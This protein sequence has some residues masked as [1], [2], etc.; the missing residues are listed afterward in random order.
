MA[1]ARDHCVKHMEEVG[2]QRCIRCD[3]LGAKLPTSTKIRNDSFFQSVTPTVLVKLTH[4]G[5]YPRYGL[6]G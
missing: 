1:L 6:D 3:L 2:I 4:S 5:S